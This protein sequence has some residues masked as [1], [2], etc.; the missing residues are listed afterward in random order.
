MTMRT[1]AW[2]GV[3]VNVPANWDLARYRYPGKGRVLLGIEDEYAGRMDLDWMAPA[4]EAL[5]RRFTERATQALES[6]IHKAD[7]QT[8]IKGL[9]TGW[10]ATHCEFSEIIP[11]KRRT[12]GLGIV[13]HDLVTAIYAP[14]DRLFRCVVR[15]HFMPGDREDPVA[16]TREIIASFQ[17]PDPAARAVLWQVFDIAWRLHPGFQIET[18]T[19]DIGSK[20]MVFRRAGRRLYLWTLSCADRLPVHDRDADTWV[21]GYL[22]STRRVTGIM[23]R[24][25]PAGVGGIGW[26]RRGPINV[27]HR[28]ELARRCFR[29]HTDYAVDKTRNQFVIRVLNYRRDSDLEWLESVTSPTAGQ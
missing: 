16:L 2:D 27:V 28:D 8:T 12:R 26:K 29:Y 11:V 18:T 10:R 14:V 13:A 20:L 6:L 1:L 23:F 15:L 21:I 19:F 5:A 22:N 3:A 4:S 25:G 24:P 9:P 7:R 17:R